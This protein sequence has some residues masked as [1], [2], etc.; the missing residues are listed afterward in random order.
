MFKKR[1]PDGEGQGT[2]RGEPGPQ[3]PDLSHTA[4]GRPG[5]RSEA[6]R[7][8]TILKG[9][10]VTGDLVVS[11]DLELSGD[12]DGNITSAEDSRISIKGTCKGNIDGG[13]IHLEGELLS[14][15][16]TAASD[17]RISGKFSGGEVKA[18]GLVHVNGEFRGRLEGNEIE[19]GANARGEGELYYRES[20][21]IAKGA[22]IEA[23]I[24]QTQQELKLVKAPAEPPSPGARS[25]QGRPQAAHGS[26]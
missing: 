13:T 10:K 1:S 17:V 12:V 5:A 9:S 15:N 14:G 23:R 6:G 26:G 19:I 16:I 18:R 8:N 20:I 21:S 7:V 22:R 11:C 25:P 4:E 2:D 3:A 24:S